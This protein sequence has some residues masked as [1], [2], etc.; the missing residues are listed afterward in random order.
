M[1]R[2]PGFVVSADTPKMVREALCAA[3]GA[4]AESGRRGIDAGRVPTWIAQLGTLID[5]CDRNRPLG[6]NGKHGSLHTPTCGCEPL[7]RREWLM[8]LDPGRS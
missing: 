6:T 3:Q 1:L 5:E 7:Y 4:L 8:V 2:S